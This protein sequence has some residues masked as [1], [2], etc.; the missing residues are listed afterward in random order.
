MDVKKEDQGRPVSQ[1]LVK[2]RKDE[3][4]NNETKTRR[5]DE[6]GK[7]KEN[8]P[9]LAKIAQPGDDVRFF[10]EAFIYPACYLCVFVLLVEGSEGWSGVE[11]DGLTTRRAG[12]RVQKVLRPS[13]EDIYFVVLSFEFL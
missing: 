7:C 1:G 3:E 8:V 12:Y 6:E 10:V 5:P 2:T 11:W 9:P 13:G 4:Y